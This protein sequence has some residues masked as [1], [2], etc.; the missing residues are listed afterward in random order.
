MVTMTEAAALDENQASRFAAAHKAIADNMEQVIRGKRDVIEKTLLCLLA[1]GHL[2]VED[3]PG[4]GKTTLAKTLAA[5]IHANL[6]RI[7]FTPDLLP[8]DVTGVSIWNRNDSVFEFR[9][10]P[11]F[12]EMVLADE[13]NRASP[14]TQSALLEAMAEA[15]VTVDG[16]THPLPKPFMVLA[17][18]NP[19]EQEGTYPLPESQLDRFLMRISVGYPDRNDEFAILQTHE[20]DGV[21]DQ[22]QPIASIADITAMIAMVSKVHIEPGLRAYLIDIAEATRQHPSIQLGMS[23]RATLSLQ[24]VARAKAAASGRNF[25]TDDDIKAVASDVVSHR[26][27]LKSDSLLRGI[28]SEDLIQDILGAVPVPHDRS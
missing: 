28:S 16:V 17:T 1:G 8:A 22:L 25:V 11:I 19:I 23:P 18:Q 20:S 10:G 9:A 15:Q 6:G 21:V 7:Q 14:K 3:I 2:L 12:A 4:V 26:L 13:I 27:I 5:S 24:R